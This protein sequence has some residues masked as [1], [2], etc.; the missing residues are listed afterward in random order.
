MQG[1]YK[2]T[3]KLNGKVYI[4]QA[5]NIEQRI[6]RH[7]RELKNQYHHNWHLQQAWNKYGQDNFSFEIIEIIDNQTIRNEHEMHWINYYNSSNYENG[8]NNTLGGNSE[9]PTEETKRKI[10]QSSKGKVF[11]EEHKKHIS[12]SWKIRKKIAQSS[13]GKVC[14]EETRKKLSEASKRR[15]ASGEYFTEESRTKISNAHKGKTVSE[16]TKRKIG[17]ANKKRIVS[18][19][20]RQKISNGNKGKTIPNEVRQKISQAKLGSKW[21]EERKQERYKYSDD[22]VIAIIQCLKNNES[23]LSISKKFNVS[24][25]VIYGIRDNKTYLHIER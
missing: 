15:I 21:T 5:N 8:Y 25:N 2:I 13:K 14:S 17:E 1:I 6:K 24:R 7:K 11:S 22:V 10:S 19:E 12:D 3:N 4:G 23:I 16:E 9:T 18:E 20:T